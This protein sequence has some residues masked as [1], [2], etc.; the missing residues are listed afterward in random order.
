MQDRGFQGGVVTEIIRT[1]KFAP[2]RFE[3]LCTPLM[4]FLLIVPAIVKML[5]MIAEDWR[6]A[7]QVTA[8]DGN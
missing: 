1:F 6:D 2:Q 8:I 4:D 3:S 7:G 5:K